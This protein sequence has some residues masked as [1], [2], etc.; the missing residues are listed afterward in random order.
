MMSKILVI[1]NK[2]NKAT[3]KKILIKMFKNFISK[4]KI[5]TIYCMILIEKKV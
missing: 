2:T 1:T 3:I 5:K 4:D